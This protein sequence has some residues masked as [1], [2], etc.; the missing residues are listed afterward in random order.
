[1]GRQCE[2]PSDHPDF[3]PEPQVRAKVLARP[4]V[5]EYADEFGNCSGCVR[6]L[7]FCYKPNLDNETLFAVEIRNQENGNVMHHAVRVRSRTALGNC[8]S[9]SRDLSDCC[10]EQMLTIP[11][12]VTNNHRFSLRVYQ[13]TSDGTAQLT[14][15]LLRHRTEMTNGSIMDLDSGRY[16]RRGTMIPKPLFFFRIDTD[17]SNI[18]GSYI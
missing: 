17:V 4:R 15:E 10:V 14:S 13:L 11:L 5:Y 3:T 6:A 12:R 18:N 1:M 16:L 8:E 7:S 9:Y 2:F